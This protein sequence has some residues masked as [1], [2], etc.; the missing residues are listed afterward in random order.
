VE[1]YEFTVAA[2]SSVPSDTTL[3]VAQA[4]LNQTLVKVLG[5]L[6]AGKL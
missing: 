1:G 4:Y 3:Q 6:R 5:A 2:R